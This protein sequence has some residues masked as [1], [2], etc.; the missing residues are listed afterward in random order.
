MA[1]DYAVGYAKPPTKTQ[2][3]AGKS[4]NPKGRPKG[5]KNLATDLEE[6]L[7][8]KLLVTEGGKQFAITK[9]RAMLKAL[10]A[11]ALKGDVRAAGTLLNLIPSVEEAQKV[12]TESV[13][14]SKADQAV[15]EAFRQKLTK[16]LK[17]EVQG[18]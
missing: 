9:Q 6:E 17:Q 3:K 15:L 2:F 5:V 16:E 12:A 14:L 10:V 7:S 11:K 13:S 8:E 18:N 4:G 1:K